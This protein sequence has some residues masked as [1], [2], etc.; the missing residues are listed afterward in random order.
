MFISQEVELTPEQK[1][2]LREEEKRKLLAS[3]Q[4]PRQRRALLI[5][6]EK[7]ENEQ[8]QQQTEGAAGTLL[9]KINMGQGLLAGGA[10]GKVML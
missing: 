7:Q 1:R 10:R 4:D 2:A 9:P 5:K 8:N 6:L 3:V